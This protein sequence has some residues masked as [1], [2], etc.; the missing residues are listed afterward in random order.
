MRKIIFIIAII[1]IIF[2][3]CKKD[4]EP[5]KELPTTY[6]F[7]YNVNSISGITTDIVLFEYND[8][9]ERIGQ[10]SINNIKKGNTKTFTANNK[11]IKV[12]VH[13]S[14][15][16]SSSSKKW[17]VQTVYYLNKGENNSIEVGDDTMVGT[18]EP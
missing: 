11:S 8:A 17:W 5:K 15:S 7:K 14:A 18:Y 6:T 10:N 16:S 12:K 2:S 4:D 9:S 13:V 1:G 3:G